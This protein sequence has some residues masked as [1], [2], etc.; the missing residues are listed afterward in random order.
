M[1][2][3]YILT[4]VGIVGP[5]AFAALVAWW[6]DYELWRASKK[7]EEEERRDRGLE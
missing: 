7:A 6:F 4:A 2:R 5:I 1:T 3:L